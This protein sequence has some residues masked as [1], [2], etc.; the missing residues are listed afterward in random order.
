MDPNAPRKAPDPKDVERLQR[1]QRRVVSVLMIT[2]VLHLTAGMLILG[3]D[4][5]DDRMDARIGLFA[6]ATVFT[7]GGI[8]GTLILNKRP[9]LSPWLILGV[10]PTAFA[11][12]WTIR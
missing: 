10:L 8:A 3:V 1:V 4:V 5:S 9:W 12:W 7:V 2:T 11:I 6:I